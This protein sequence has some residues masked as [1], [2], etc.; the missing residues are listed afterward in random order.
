VI[1]NETEVLNLKTRKTQVPLGY[2]TQK[3]KEKSLPQM[4]QHAL[5][6]ILP[7]AS[8][9]AEM[10]ERIIMKG[11]ER[12]LIVMRACI[13]ANFLKD[14]IAYLKRERTFT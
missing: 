13:L 11:G 8:S 7:L 14:Q 5:V 6:T 2:L 10:D 12:T 3:R 4:T 1:R 9:M